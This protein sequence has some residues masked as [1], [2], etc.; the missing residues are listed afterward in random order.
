M[1]GAWEKPPQSIRRWSDAGLARYAADG[2]D[3]GNRGARRDV[4]WDHHVN[5]RQN[6]NQYGHRYRVCSAP[7]R[8]LRR[9]SRALGLQSRDSQVLRN[10]SLE[11]PFGRGTVRARNAFR[12]STHRV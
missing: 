1:P 7:E 4:R 9:W 8:E 11:V 10:G 3:N 12:T 5:L 6:F 2:P